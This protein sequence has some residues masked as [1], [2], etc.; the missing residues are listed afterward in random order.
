MHRTNRHAK[1]VRG[2]AITNLLYSQL[3][4]LRIRS[5]FYMTLANMPF[6]QIAKDHL[7]TT[8]SL[9]NLFTD[10]NGDYLELSQQ[11]IALHEIQTLKTKI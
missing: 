2:Q 7:S 11:I 10:N 4:T 1:N 6:P 9:S 8:L 3:K 5:I